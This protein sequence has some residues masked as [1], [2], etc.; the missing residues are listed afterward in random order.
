MYSTIWI[1]K[2]FFLRPFIT[3][4]VVRV[5][6]LPWLSGK[7]NWPMR[8]E[9]RF[10][11]QLLLNTSH[12]L[13]QLFHYENKLSSWDRVFFSQPVFLYK[14]FLVFLSLRVWTAVS[15]FQLVC[16]HIIC[17]M[18]SVSAASHLAVAYLRC[19]WG[20]ARI[21]FSLSDVLTGMLMSTVPMEGFPSETGCLRLQH[22]C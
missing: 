15:N 3:Q 8:F 4:E 10:S 12:G 6:F 22:W 20:K 18:T 13:Q 11:G 14:V 21:F 9:H 5:N 2:L 16:N 1:L 19:C 17:L 7:W